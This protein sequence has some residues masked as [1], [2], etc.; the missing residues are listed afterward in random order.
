[1][2]FWRSFIPLSTDQEGSL[3]PMDA[4]AIIALVAAFTTPLLGYLVATRRLSGRIATSEATDLWKEASKMRED[5]LKRIDQLTMLVQTCQARIEELE[6]RNDQ[7]HRENSDLRETVEA[8]ELTISELRKLVHDISEENKVLKAE[9]L[10]LR[11]RLSE[12][13]KQGKDHHA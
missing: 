12:L 13:E 10:S 1:M 3:F 6:R 11:L 5:Y 8:H 2:R 7:L 9:N 4:A